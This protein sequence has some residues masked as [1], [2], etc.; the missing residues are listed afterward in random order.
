MNKSYEIGFLHGKTGGGAKSYKP[1]CRKIG[2]K[3]FA[4]YGHGFRDGLI[5]YHQELASRLKQETA[6]VLK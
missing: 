4:L 1:G 2:G 6:E 3:A 5:A